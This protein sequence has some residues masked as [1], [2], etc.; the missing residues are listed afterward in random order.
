M[1]NVSLGTVYRNLNIL[2]EQGVI[3]EIRYAG[4]QSRFDG[5]PSP[6]YHFTCVDCEQVLDVDLPRDTRLEQQ[7]KQLRPDLEVIGH[8]IEFFGRCPRCARQREE[9]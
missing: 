6:H 9:E 1:P 7:L 4:Q 3:Q 8:N 2:K 5:N